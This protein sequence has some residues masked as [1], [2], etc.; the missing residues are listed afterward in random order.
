[1]HYVM[2]YYK[3]VYLQS[4]NFSTT[5]LRSDIDGLIVSLAEL[6]RTDD[7]SGATVKREGRLFC[8]IFSQ[9]E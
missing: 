9:Y 7:I 1:M 2:L 5:S 6:I 3:I 8:W 4:L